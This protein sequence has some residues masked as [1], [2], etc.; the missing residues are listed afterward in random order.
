MDRASRKGISEPK[1]AGYRYKKGFYRDEAVAAHYDRERFAGP[2][3]RRRNRRKWRTLRRGLA[4][5]DTRVRRVV[6]LPC[7]TGRF[8]GDLGGLG[9]DVVGC[10]ISSEMMREAART[11]AG[12]DRVR[13]FVQADAEALP[14]ADDAFDAVVSIRFMFHVDPATRVEILR[15]F[16]RIA[17]YQVVDYR[18]RY[19]YRYAKWRALGAL[20][21]TRRALER[22]S[23]QGLEG[24]LRDAGLVLRDVFPVARV[25]SDKWIVVAERA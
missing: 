15:E 11:A 13:G 10:D 3:R 17:P 22:V 19:S 14:F 6:D 1:R 23:R 25:L 5:L 16:G 4:S 9:I 24:E 2:F 18:H 20:G 21:L 8:T 7:G 12:T